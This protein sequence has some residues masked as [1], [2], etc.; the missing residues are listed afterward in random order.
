[1][2]AEEVGVKEE[3]VNK[4]LRRMQ[5]RRSCHGRGLVRFRLSML[6]VFCTAAVC[7]C[8][9]HENQVKV[10]S[11]FP[12]PIYQ[13]LSKKEVGQK[14]RTTWH[15]A[16]HVPSCSLENLFDMLRC[17]Y[18]VL[19]CTHNMYFCILD[20]SVSHR[21]ISLFSLKSEVGTAPE[22]TMPSAISL[23]TRAM[24]HIPNGFD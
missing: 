3:W 23:M 4:Q 9:T 7:S 13:H 1:M 12:H 6:Y 20:S 22:Q 18:H 16:R 21:R 2:I 5:A 8:H 17:L 11:T 15:L 24:T 19:V 10:I 14:F